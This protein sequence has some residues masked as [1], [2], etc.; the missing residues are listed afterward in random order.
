MAKTTTSSKDQENTP[1]GRIV[2]IDVAS[3]MQGSFLEY[4]Y[5]VIYSRALPDARDGL[6][7]VQ[8]RILHTMAQMNLKSDRGHVKSARVVGEVMGKLHPH[9]DSAIYDALVRMAQSWSL[10]LPFVDGHGNFGSLDEGPA[11]YRYTE[12]RLAA[13][14][15]AMVDSLDEDTVDFNPN[16]DGRELEPAV[17][18]AAIPSLLV[19]GASGIA[20]GMATNMPPHNLREVT[21]AAVHL[22]NNPKAT[23]D[24]LMEFV[25]GPDLPTGGLIV[26][27]D[28]IREA[29][30][31]GKGSFRVRARVDI[32][33]VSAKR[34]GL[35]VRELPYQ[36]GPERVIERIKDLVTSKKLQGISD[37][38]DLTD[39]E[40]G[41]ELVIELKNGFNPQAVLDQLYKQTP[42]EDSFHI[43]NVAL[44][45][46]Q[47]VT[48]GLKELL[49]VFIKHRLEVV[50]RRS[51][52]RRKKAQERLHLV[53]GLLIAILDI[54]KVIKLIRASEDTAAARTGLMKTFK[55][56]ELQANHILEMPLRRLTKFSKLE[57]QKEQKEL[58][59][60]IADLTEIL[61]SSKRLKKVVT[62]ELNEMADQ[63][64][65]DRRS[66]LISEDEIISAASSGPME[67]EDDPCYVILSASGLLARTTSA[68]PLEL[69]KKRVN[70]DTIRSVVKS[71]ARAEIG[72]VT[73]AGRVLRL[74]VIGLPALP[75]NANLTA[76]GGA[77]IK[78]FITL[79]KD[80][81]PLALMN[82]TDE[83][84][85]LVVFTASG[86]VKRVNHDVPGSAKDW[87]ILKLDQK[88]ALVGAVQ[89]ADDSGNIILITDDAQLL[90]FPANTVRA[91]GRQAG[92][93][94]GIKLAKG[95]KVIYGSVI[96]PNPQTLVATVAGKDATSSNSLK[97]SALSEF[98]AKGRATGGVRCH[99]FLSG[100]KYLVTAGA[101]NAP[102]HASTN[103]GGFVEVPEKLGKR[104][105]TGTV[106]SKSVAAVCALP[107]FK[108]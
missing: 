51:E 6:K 79:P 10:R 60:I 15:N 94:A 78:E 39:Y 75:E 34:T 1:G 96:E 85:T 65:D 11:A 47:P 58:Q 3:E 55:L 95:A 67:V 33:R 102:I 49:D 71:S 70:H 106:L 7:P 76:S 73:S 99:K 68:T 88:D 98:P 24:D 44:V 40:S 81:K 18:P 54:D 37:V 103:T 53:D 36:V 62:Q 74:G 90:H 29:Y 64:G 26:G 93:V 61:T 84:S 52:F 17:L 108:S 66:D 83:K 20:V 92:C 4:A 86:Q 57:L 27:L 25:P 48:L 107:K 19:N 41:L 97:V 42:L 2:D 89:T 63:Y 23:L 9:G 45:E 38:I 8:R 22:L 35:V 21:A 32:E 77:A 100:E 13:A 80:E 59:A 28:G 72:L 69:G 31:L 101:G 50:K 91:T 104:D 30:E 82:L 5:S 12:A 16:Y 46:G 43:N 105:A 14:A 56:S 87:N